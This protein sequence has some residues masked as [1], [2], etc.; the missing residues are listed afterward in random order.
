MEVIG[1]SGGILNG[2]DLYFRLALIHNRTGLTVSLLGTICRYH[3]IIHRPRLYTSVL[4]AHLP[5][6]RLLRF[7]NTLMQRSPL[8][9]NGVPSRDRFPY[10]IFNFAH[11]PYHWLLLRIK[12]S[13]LHLISR[14]LLRQGICYLVVL[15]GYML[16]LKR[17]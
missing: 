4:P 13:A 1:R 14:R 8:V 2:T 7:H 15:S 9:P 16:N 3:H 6:S 17:I 5:I 12:P 10:C 11:T